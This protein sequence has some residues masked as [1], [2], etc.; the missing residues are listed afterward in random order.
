MIT[1]M[2]RVLLALL[3]AFFVLLAVTAMLN[4]RVGLAELAVA[5]VVS[6]ILY[7][8]FRRPK[9]AAPA[10]APPPS[11]DQNPVPV[12]QFTHSAE[13]ADRLLRLKYWG[14]SLIVLGTVLQFLLFWPA[15]LMFGTVVD[16]SRSRLLRQ[17]E[18]TL[19]RMVRDGH[20]ALG[21]SADGLSHQTSGR[22]R[23]KGPSAWPPGVQ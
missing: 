17:G 4:D 14:I 6:V 8:D 23:H 7:R 11:P 20:P 10:G 5:L 9:P 19:Y 1:V 2:T 15:A 21:R 16:G 3:G 13:E 18:G 12:V 22:Q